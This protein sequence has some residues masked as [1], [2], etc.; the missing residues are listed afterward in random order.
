MALSFSFH[1][2]FP[3]IAAGVLGV[4]C[5][6]APQEK[7]V[8][9][10]LEK[11]EDGLT[12]AKGS[13]TPYSGNFTKITKA[14]LKIEE[15]NYVDG[16]QDGLEI[17]YFEDG[18]VKRRAE[19]VK[20]QM[21]H[22]KSWWENGKLKSDEGIRNGG[23]WG[24]CSYFYEDGRLRK[25]GRFIEDYHVDGHCVLYAPDGTLE[26]DAVFDRGVYMGGICRVKLAPPQVRLHIPEG[27]DEN[28][29][30]IAAPQQTVTSNLL[31]ENTQ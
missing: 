8:R 1:R 26:M 9:F 10:E 21:V 12:Y 29:D 17:R 20:G 7:A 25:Q 22:R 18:K 4:S 11:R 30:V 6:P 16:L 15:T 27:L 5:S 14:A 23:P 28:G 31:P 24:T 13:M 2:L 19:W 3:L